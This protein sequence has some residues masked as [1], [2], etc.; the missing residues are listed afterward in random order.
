MTT[1][2]RPLPVP[3]SPPTVRY[4]GRARAVLVQIV[5]GAC[6]SDVDELG[7]TEELVAF[8]EDT[9]AYAPRYLAPALKLGL[10]ALDAASVL[11]GGGTALSKMTP[12]RARAYVEASGHGPNVP[13]TAVI[14]QVRLL[15]RMGYFEHP[16]VHARMR[17]DAAAWIVK[18][19]KERLVRHA[20]DL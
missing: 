8:V 10:L 4:R 18:V 7:I 2:R 13:R 14:P 5:R 17:Y 11:D 12:E 16:L 9:L 20:D 1:T 6:P 15:A 3:G 19:K